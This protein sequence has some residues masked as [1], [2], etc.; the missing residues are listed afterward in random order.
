MN[1]DE[2][3]VGDWLVGLGHAVR[4]L[5][6]GEDPPDL[7]VDGN[8]AVEVTTIASYAF[9]SVWDF[10]E[11]ICK[12]LG[13]AQNGRGYFILVSSND[14][15]LLQGKDRRL[16]TAMKR[17]L[18][19]YAKIALR[20]YYR[21]PDAT[22]LQPLESFDYEDRIDFFPIGG[23]IRLPYGVELRIAGPICDNR[24]DVKYEV[25]GGGTTAVWVVPQL[26]DVIQSAIRKKTD[27]R[28]IKER[29]EMYKE[30]W[31]VVTDPQYTT[32]LDDDEVQAIA[33]AINYGEPW[34]R[35]L[36]A[37]SATEN[38]RVIDLSKRSRNVG[39]SDAA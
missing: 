19:Y 3:L 11:S 23:R 31:L 10:M 7:V 35:I 33:M 2:K 9:R 34:R 26:V 8:I 14:Q 27:L 17:H 21:N 39:A 32:R 13:A 6:N 25:A 28:T 18:K 5:G 15:A 1:Q 36:L 37:D 22:L 30:W 20:N 24:S 12:S 29:A 4:H 38:G 16:V